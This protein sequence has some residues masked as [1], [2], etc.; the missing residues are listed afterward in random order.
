MTSNLNARTKGHFDSSDGFDSCATSNFG[1][2]IRGE[3]V[4]TEMKTIIRSRPMDLVYFTSRRMFHWNND[5]EG[6]RGSFVFNVEKEGERKWATPD[7]NGYSH[8]IN[9]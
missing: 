1:D 4:L 9:K 8:V 7:N 5:Y 3:L 6:R 2:F